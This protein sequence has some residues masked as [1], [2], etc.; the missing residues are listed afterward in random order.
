MSTSTTITNT[1]T[2]HQSCNCGD[3]EEKL[4]FQS[5]LENMHYTVQSYSGRGMY[6]TKCL[7]IMTDACIP[8]F[9]SHVLSNIPF[10][11]DLPEQYRDTVQTVSSA[12]RCAKY[13]ELGRSYIIYFPGIPFDN[14][15][16]GE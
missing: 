16:N 9:F 1:T 7:G 14:H 6:N 8:Q 15:E 5:I 3:E 13:D 4:S 2:T 10:Y 12:L 11:E